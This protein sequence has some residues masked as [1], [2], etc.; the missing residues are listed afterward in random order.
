MTSA[1]KNCLPAQC[2]IPFS[3]VG[4]IA[5]DMDSTAI[6]IECIDEIADFAGVKAEVSAVI[7]AAKRFPVGG[8]G[9]GH[10]A[11]ESP[12]A[13]ATATRRAQLVKSC[14]PLAVKQLA[15]DQHAADFIRA[16]PDLVEF[17]VTQ[18][19]PGRVFVDITVAA[20]ALD[21]FERDLH[22]AGGSV[23]QA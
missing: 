21:C 13:A 1:E 16:S 3:L 20:Q 18:D 2:A 8:N 14:S 17:C 5:M 7:E 15:P 9:R 23:Q 22:S 12:L 4:L 10:G 6:T 11:M 19:A